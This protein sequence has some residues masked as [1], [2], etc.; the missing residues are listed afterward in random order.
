M[1]FFGKTLLSAA[2]LAGAVQAEDAKAAEKAPAVGEDMKKNIDIASFGFGFNTGKQVLQQKD[3]INAEE[4]MKGLQ[5]ALAKNDK[6][7]DQ[8]K[9]AQAMQAVQ[10]YM[11]EKQAAE[12][13]KAAEVGAKF[14]EANKAKEGVK[15][16]ASGLQY[17]VITAST[18]KDA[19]S[20]TAADQVKVHY[21]GTLPDGKVFD[22][23]VDRGQPVTFP[24]GQVVKG[25]TEGLQL[26]KEG[27]KFQLVVPDELG[28]NGRGPGGPGAVMIFEVE[29]LEVIE[30]KAAPAVTITPAEPAK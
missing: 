16:T 2:L 30:A 20:P 10:K 21:H 26:M 13:A 17:K 3:M 6:A 14:L 11:Q 18:K 9:F 29:L 25:W 22:S 23:S 28:Y 8:A 4:F 12:Q 15:V 7:F 27:D 24:L 1:K 5:A 19:K